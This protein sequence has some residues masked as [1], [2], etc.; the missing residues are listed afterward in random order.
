MLNVLDDA[1]HGSA[2]QDFVLVVHG[3]DQEE[4][5][6]PWLVVQNLTESVSFDHKVI[7]LI[8]AGQP[9]IHQVARGV[10]SHRMW[11]R[12]NACE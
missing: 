10:D 12:Y 11:R 7:R 6:S 5:C 3:Q 2:E 8:N 1:V 9:S 4:L